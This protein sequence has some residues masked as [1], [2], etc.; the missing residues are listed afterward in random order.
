MTN[1]T[2][3]KNGETIII[4]H[5]TNLPRPYSWGFTLHGNG[6]VLFIEGKSPQ[7]NWE[8]GENYAKYFK[9]YDHKIWK[10]EAAKAEGAGHGGIDYF[11]IKSF[12]ESVRD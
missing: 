8:T 6:G 2:I 5:D 7:H 9:K 11:T 1:E 3:N 10:E 4:S 12:L